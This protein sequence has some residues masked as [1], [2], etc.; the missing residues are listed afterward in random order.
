M[1]HDVKQTRHRPIWVYLT[2]NF[3]WSWYTKVVSNCCP[4]NPKEC[5]SE[6]R[7]SDPGLVA[8]TKRFGLCRVV[9]VSNSVKE[10][11]GIIVVNTN[12]NAGQLAPPSA[13]GPNSVSFYQKLMCEGEDV[14]VEKE[15]DKG[16]PH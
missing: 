7:G 15:N 6:T 3:W 10:T 1:A 8:G 12:A 13:H 5:R 16:R 14:F 11:D 4:E 2:R 9:V